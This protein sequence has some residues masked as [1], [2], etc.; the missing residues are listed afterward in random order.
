[1]HQEKHAIC[2]DADVRLQTINPE[3]GSSLHR[4]EGIFGRQ[5]RGAAVSDQAGLFRQHA[6][7]DIP[8]GLEDGD[9]PEDEQAGRD[10][11]FLL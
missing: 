7:I 8:R 10:Q 11:D 5:G 6:A 2:A 4:G 9:Q 3:V 1:M